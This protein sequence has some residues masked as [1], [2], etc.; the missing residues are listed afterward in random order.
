M[1]YYRA[2]ASAEDWASSD[3]EQL[4][5]GLFWPGLLNKTYAQGTFS[6]IEVTF[7][8]WM[9]WNWDQIRRRQTIPAPIALI[10]FLAQSETMNTLLAVA[11]QILW[12]GGSSIERQIPS[13][14]GSLQDLIGGM[15]I[16]DDE[17]VLDVH[18][19]SNSVRPVKFDLSYMKALVEPWASAAL[20]EILFLATYNDYFFAQAKIARSCQATSKTSS[21]FSE[22]QLAG[23]LL[24]KPYE[25]ALLWSWLKEEVQNLSRLQDEYHG[26]IHADLPLPQDYEQALK[27]VNRLVYCWLCQI[28]TEISYVHEMDALPRKF[29]VGS[30]YDD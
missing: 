14:E 18:K 4:R 22:A 17:C 3:L 13:V 12:Q 15:S 24:I 29:G 19:I 27:A 23:D 25:T 7:G 21:P 16:D 2:T 5:Y 8:Q 20:D 11:E 1:L 6:V 30:R 26:G 28:F 9:P 10:F